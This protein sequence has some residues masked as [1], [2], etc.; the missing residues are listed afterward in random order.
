MKTRRTGLVYLEILAI[1]LF[2]IFLFPFLIV[3]A[4]S[5][6]APFEI[7]QSPLSLPTNWGK[8]LENMVSIWTA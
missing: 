3:L 7:T 2:L 4:N 6:K 1:V 8:I 5:A